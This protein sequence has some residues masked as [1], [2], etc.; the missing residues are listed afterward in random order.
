MY[1]YQA[2][3]FV[4]LLLLE[5]LS[6]HAAS[7]MHLARRTGRGHSGE[8]ILFAA[9]V[10]SYLAVVFLVLSPV[11]A[12]VFTLMQQGLLGLYLGCSFAPNHKGMAMLNADDHSDFLRRQVLTSRN[13][14]VPPL[15]VSAPGSSPNGSPRASTSTTS[16]PR[17]SSTTRRD[18]HCVPRPP[19]TTRTTSPSAGG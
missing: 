14:H 5:A 4:P 11:K 1:R 16:T 3:V 2:H 12:V 17:S 8:R 10:A 15:A 7:A 9:H 6:L 13:V 18:G 19:S